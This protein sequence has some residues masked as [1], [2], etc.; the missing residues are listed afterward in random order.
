MR[1][2][3]T[4]IVAIVVLAAFTMVVTACG[5]QSRDMFSGTWKSTSTAVSTSTGTSTSAGASLTIA[6]SGDGWTI[7]DS[8]G[9][10]GRGTLQG[11]SLVSRDF[12][13]KRYNDLLDV[14]VAGK[15][16]M[17]MAKQ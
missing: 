4:A 6:K 17:V 10:T 12:T 14:Y 13:F 16:I 3:K 11:S 7:T 9:Q 1:V 15:L 8:H 2:A 5:S